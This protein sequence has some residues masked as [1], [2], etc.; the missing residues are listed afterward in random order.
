MPG[1]QEKN[2]VISTI[3]KYISVITALTRLKWVEEHDFRGVE[4]LML[5]ALDFVTGMLS[6]IPMNS[7]EPL[8]EK[9]LRILKIN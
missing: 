3:E 4:V 7:K 6:R 9:L 2:Q 8:L 1:S 5:D